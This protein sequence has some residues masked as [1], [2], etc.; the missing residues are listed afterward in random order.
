MADW[1]LRL[2]AFLDTQFTVVVA[3]LLVLAILGGWMSY[4]AYA[5]PGTTTEERSTVEWEQ[6]GEFE[7]TATVTEENSVFPTGTT[8][9]N[10][11]VYFV[12][13]SPRL[14]GQFRTT[15]HARDDGELDQ[16]VSV[17]LVIREVGSGD[18]R[19]NETVYWQTSD[20]LADSTADAV[21]P[22]E[23]VSVQFSQNMSAVET[24]VEQIRDEIGS[25]PGNTEVFVR[26][27][28]SSQG[29][30]NGNQVNE[31]NVYRLPVTFDGS[32]YRI[33]SPEPI[34]EQYETI[35]T[36]T[37]AQTAGT[38]RSIGGP[39]LLI[40]SLGLLGG[41]V[42]MFNRGQRSE[43]E[44]ALFT[45]EDDRETFDDWISTIQ[46]PE[47]AFNLPRANATSLGTLV[48]FAID[49]DNSVIEDP[50]GNAYYV[51]H[52]GYLYVYHPPV[53]QSEGSDEVSSGGD[54]GQTTV[55]SRSTET[56]EQRSEVPN[57]SPDDTT[58][59]E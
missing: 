16:T 39:L 3:V 22:A 30:V 38:T 41:V 33:G 59:D 4:T 26:A 24:R 31:T 37:V 47:E 57:E 45:D 58:T 5:A 20:S 32:T 43:A 53:Q 56:P 50:D 21:S 52:D 46:L 18:Q 48:D 9:A 29:T 34:V 49:T 15:Y 7:H 13:L 42:T 11:S 55:D 2:R 12:R 44:R 19:E 8:L 6:T 40:I 17:S 14:D 10:R 27:V 35:Q 51:R 54:D 1:K 25:S 36:E 23:P 28:V